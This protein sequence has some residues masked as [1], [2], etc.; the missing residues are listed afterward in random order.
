MNVQR[1]WFDKD[2]YAI[3][4]VHPG[5]SQKDIS[6]AYRKLARQYHPDANPGDTVAEERF[7]EITAAYDVIGDPERRKEYDQ[8]RAMGPMAGGPGGRFEGIRFDATNI[9]DL[10]GDLFGRGPDS[11]F[12]PGGPFSPGP[13]RGADLEAD[14]HLSFLDAIRGVTTSVHLVSEVTCPD[15]HGTG[16]APGTTPRVCPDCR[17]RGILDENQGLFSFSRP[18]STCRGRGQFIDTPCPTCSG[19]GVTTRPRM[20]KVRLPAGVRDGQQI[21]L[22]GKGAPGRNNGPPG[23]L[24]VRVHVDKHPVFGRDGD[25]L[26][27]TVP[28]SYP[29]AVL[30]ADVKVPTIDGDSVTI[31]I[32]PGTPSG[33]IMR[34]RNRGVPRGGDARGDLLVT[35]E[36]AVPTELTDEERRAVEALR[37]VMTSSPRLEV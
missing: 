29:D 30:G 21:R 27:V 5:A 7:K 23:D 4:G 16:A 19:T 2:Y 24:Y 9:G 22:K 17:G 26:T 8:V 28:V 14:L 3:L 36:I 15:C 35:I 12:G 6:S 37:D 25:N 32:P 13:H 11:R 20:V 18:C 33:R 31:R 10:L 34:V 1:E